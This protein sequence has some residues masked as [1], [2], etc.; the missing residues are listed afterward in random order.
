M[1]LGVGDSE[2][3]HLSASS[4]LQALRMLVTFFF[5]PTN[6]A[7]SPSH[8]LEEFYN[9]HDKMVLLLMS[10]LIVRN[11]KVQLHLITA[12]DFNATHIELHKFLPK[13]E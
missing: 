2:G 11:I 7:F 4:Q 12:I 5:F 1:R 3:V 10:Y 8:Q 13:S 9:Y 6:T